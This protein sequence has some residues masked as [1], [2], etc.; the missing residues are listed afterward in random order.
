MLFSINHLVKQCRQISECSPEIRSERINTVCTHHQ[1]LLYIY[2]PLKW[3]QTQKFSKNKIIFFS[4]NYIVCSQ[5]RHWFLEDWMH[6]C[7]W[8][9]FGQGSARPT[10]KWQWCYRTLANHQIIRRH[11]AVRV[12]KRLL[13]WLSYVRIIMRIH[14]ATSTKGNVMTI[15]TWMLSREY[16]AVLWHI[17]STL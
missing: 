11:L 7:L 12:Q 8:L 1:Y 17:Y 15:E 5:N 13:F 6:I 16:H 2:V 10:L 9:S 3:R 4:T 14:E